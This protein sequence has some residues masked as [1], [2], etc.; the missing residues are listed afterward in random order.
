MT[1]TTPTPVTNAVPSPPGDRL[2]YLDAT[3]AFAL[4]LGVVFHAS[5]SFLPFWIGWAVQDV[6][7]HNLMGVFITVSHSFRMELFFLLAGFFSHMTIGRKGWANFLRS[8]LVRIA[9]PFV[10]GWMLLR[11]LLVAVFIAGGES[12]RGDY[13]VWSS[14]VTGFR[15]TVRTPAEYLTG[16]HLWFL[17]YLLMI[18]GLVAGG[19]YLLSLHRASAAWL[20]KVVDRTMAWWAGS[21]WTIPVAAL[22]GFGLLRL[23]SNWGVDTPDKALAPHWPVLLLYG[24]FFAIGWLVDRQR[25]ILPRLTRLSWKRGGLTLLATAIV[26]VLIPLQM[27]PGN[28]RAAIGREIYSAAYAVMMWS[29]VLLTIGLFRHWF[30]QPKAWVRYVA[31]SSYWMYLVHLPV[32]IALQVIVAEWS[33]SWMIKWPLVSALTVACCILTYDLGVRSTWVGQ[34]LNG[35]KRERVIFRRRENGAS[36]AAV[37]SAN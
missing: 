24:G 11:P 23:M 1:P 20:R 30:S 10:I 17:Y 6:S 14:L 34:V 31:D 18:T 8:R 29:L 2:A 12:M 13:H 9:L 15:M 28:P 32:V 35:R 5:L 26:V 22:P 36:L 19:G 16:T 27:D 33:L 4:V 7:G 25:K 37:T 3:R 21:I